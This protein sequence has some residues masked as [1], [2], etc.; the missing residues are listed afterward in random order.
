MSDKVKSGS[1]KNAD[2][3]KKESK[4][5]RRSKSADKSASK[6]SMN[7]NI[8]DQTINQTTAQ[9]PTVDKDQQPAVNSASLNMSD[10]SSGAVES[11]QIFSKYDLYKDGKL[12]KQ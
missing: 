6:K 2:T 7:E 11:C 12:D 10:P 3:R 4:K 5:G 8:G 1:N 9:Q